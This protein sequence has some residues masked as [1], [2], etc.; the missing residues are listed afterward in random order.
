MK[1]NYERIWFFIKLLFLLL[2]PTMFRWINFGFIYHSIFWAT[3][4]IVA[5]F[6]AAAILFSFVFGRIACGWICPFGTLMDL[7]SKY[8][9]FKDKKKKPRWWL[10]SLFLLLF[11]SAALSAAI[12]R[13][14]MGAIHGVRFDPLF[15]STEFD[16]HYK[17][18]W[19]FDTVGVLALGLILG[20]RFWCRNVCFMGFLCALG[21]KFQRFIAVVDTSK[22]RNCGSCEKKCPA[23][24]PIMDYVK[25]ANGLVHDTECVKCGICIDGCRFHAIDLR[26]VWN[27]K[28]YR[29]SAV[30]QGN[31]S[32]SIR[33]AAGVRAVNRE[34]D[35]GWHGTAAGTLNIVGSPS[36][37]RDPSSI[38]S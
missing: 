30:G 21:S 10:R 37:P 36:R 31:P 29:K 12:I 22:C 1:I 5:L 19:M 16:L 15:L 35:S 7:G 11:L 8:S 4:T 3:I 34:T 25:N 20:N 6:W 27:R 26:M 28:R 33:G 17:L 9:F 24:V 2:A 14:G 18:V 32:P 38:R 23:G 13:Y